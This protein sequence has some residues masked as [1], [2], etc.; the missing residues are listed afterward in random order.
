MLVKIVRL[1]F[2]LLNE[3]I[4]AGRNSDKIFLSNF[5]FCFL[6]IVDNYFVLGK[7]HVYFILFDFFGFRCSR[8]ETD[9]PRMKIYKNVRVCRQCYSSIKEERSSFPN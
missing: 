9:I 7:N 6:E 5:H 3:D 1:D 4:I 8:F 2:H